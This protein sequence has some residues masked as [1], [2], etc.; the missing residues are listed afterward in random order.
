MADGKR[1]RRRRGR[2]GGG[3]RPAGDGARDNTAPPEREA[4]PASDGNDARAPR[5]DNRRGG[6]ADRPLDTASPGPP[7]GPGRPAG[8]GI[9]RAPQQPS[10]GGQRRQRD[11]RGSRPRSEDRASRTRD[12]GGSRG[13]SR[14]RGPRVYEAPVPQD[15]QSIALGAAFREA[16]TALRDARKTLDKR[17]AEAGD[18]PEW[19]L[20]QYA[21][22]EQRFEMAASAWS[23]HLEKT[24][25]KVVRR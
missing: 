7:P 13:G 23:E 8:G 11:D 12:D 21:D 10:D 5:R 14:D 25:R 19:L 17:K 9:R 3:E 16:Q 15:E 20:Q 22:A 24:G 18:E 1:S 6:R 2:R 4:P